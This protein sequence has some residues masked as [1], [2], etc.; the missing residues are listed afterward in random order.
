MK[1]AMVIITRRGVVV[2]AS[3]SAREGVTRE[4]KERRK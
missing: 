3:D 4:R 2:R 1:Q